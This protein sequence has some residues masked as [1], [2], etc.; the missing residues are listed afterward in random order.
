MKQIA[1]KMGY[2]LFAFFFYMNRIFT[3]VNKHKVFCIMTHDSSMDSNVGMIIQEMK[4]QDANYKFYYIKKEETAE[5]KNGGKVRSMLSFFLVKPFHMATAGYIFLDNTFLPM[6]YL[7]FSSKAKVVQLWHG[8]GTIKKFGQDA[9]EG[10]LKKLENHANRTITHLIV[11]AEEIREQY[12]GAFGVEF[13]KVYATGLPRTDVLFDRE[14]KK[15]D[16][17]NFYNQYPELKHKKLVLYAPTF[18]D[19]EVANPKMELDLDTFINELPE[20]TVCMI[21]LHPFVARQYAWTKEQEERYKDRVV[22]LSSYADIT[23]LLFVADVLITDYSSIIYE[24]CLREKPMIFFA[25]D[26]ETF[27]RSG[28]GFYEPYEESVP[29]MVVRTTEE[30]V[31]AIKL[32]LYEGKYDHERIE[33]F[34][35]KYYQYFDGK[36]TER[37]IKLV[38]EYYFRKNGEVIF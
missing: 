15:V 8:T 35:D 24:Y 2:L 14:K 26:L 29:G 20:D 37:V 3:R 6:A 30:V 27:E 13:D 10:D 28:R 38:M 22:N 34:R 7:R 21:K 1:K 12:A 4:K 9:N 16:R 31:E 32:N 18:R 19:N 25:Y 36:S 17:A 33:W 23:T 11:N 5:V